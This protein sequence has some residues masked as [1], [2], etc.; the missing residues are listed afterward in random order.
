MNGE[1]YTIH[2]MLLNIGNIFLG[3]PCVHISSK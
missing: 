2:S 1:S 3:P